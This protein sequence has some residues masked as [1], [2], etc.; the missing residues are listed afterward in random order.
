[1]TDKHKHIDTAIRTAEVAVWGF[2]PETLH[3]WK[4]EMARALIAKLIEGM[5]SPE[6]DHYW[7]GWDAAIDEIR[8]MVGLG[9]D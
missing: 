7:T 5:V 8:S 9:V 2:S 1:M 3:P 4:R 6:E